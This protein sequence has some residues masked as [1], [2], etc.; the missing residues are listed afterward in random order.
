MDIE[1]VRAFF[2]IVAS[3]SLARAVERLHLSQTAASARIRSLEA[4]MRRPLFVR[5]KSGA[6]LAPVGEQF[7]RY[8]T[9]E[10]QLLAGLAEAAASRDP[11]A[12]ALLLGEIERAQVVPAEAGLETFAAHLPIVLT[13]GLHLH[14]RDDE[15]GEGAGMAVRGRSTRGWLRNRRGHPRHIAAAPQRSGARTAGGRVVWGDGQAPAGWVLA[16]ARLQSWPAMRR[17]AAT[18]LIARSASACNCAIA[19][20]SWAASAWAR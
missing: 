14:V 3:G 10:E 8:A 15:A 5:G 4:Q 17:S 11:T 9:A 16:T 6:A 7:L 18:R 12:S 19:A 1:L 13:K 2:A 20:S